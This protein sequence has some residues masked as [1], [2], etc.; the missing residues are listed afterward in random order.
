MVFDVI[1]AKNMTSVRS[2]YVRLVSEYSL[3]PVPGVSERVDILSDIQRAIIE[4]KKLILQSLA[5]DFEYRSEYDSIVTEFVP[6]I[7]AI[8]YVKKNI[9]EWA[10]PS[11]RK[12]SLWFKFARA[13]VEYHP[14]GVVGIISPWNFP[15]YLS[16]VPL[17]YAIAS[18]NRVLLKP[19]ERSPNISALLYGLFESGSLSKY[20]KVVIADAKGSVEFSQ[21][22]FDHLL[23][24]GSTSVGR[25]IAES[26][27]KN[28]VPLTL[29]L[30]GK[31]P[32]FIDS[33]VDLSA[34]AK[35]IVFGK[36]VNG[37][38]TCV[39]P[40][41]LLVHSSDV[42]QIV[43]HLKQEAK[44]LYGTSK[45]VDLTRVFSERELVRVKHLLGD[46]ESLGATIEPLFDCHTHDPIVPSLVLNPKKNSALMREE[47]FAPV[48]PLVVYEEHSEAIDYL[49]QMGSPLVIY[50]F[51]HSQ[52]VISNIKNHTRSGAILIN[53]CNI[54]VV[55]DDLPFGG[56]GN[57][58]YGRYHG[59]E[60]FRE[61]S[62][63]R[64]VMYQSKFNFL[65]FLYPP[66]K[67]RMKKWLIK[68]MIKC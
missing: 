31:S 29:E 14:K 42:K 17:I 58:G 55:Q 25:R 10:S 35:K 64:S 12:I 16:I 28:L 8:K 54:H 43:N 21:I 40:D 65:R 50:V 33:G 39:A 3:N 53:D 46:A 34:V 22:E 63:S 7:L 23:F 27:A 48:L 18:G 19:S 32:V 15:L 37:G 45:S 51:S 11:K 1:S 41:Y 52:S 6:T 57:S 68:L 47:I 59:V 61:F 9:K 67:G 44:K 62:N 38:Q 49:T 5:K 13:Y 24:T 56:V 4:N 60:G 30:G 20:V 36:L 26:A 2:S 66:F